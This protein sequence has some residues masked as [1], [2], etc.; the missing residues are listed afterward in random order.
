ML[1]FDW[2]RRRAAE[3]VALGIADGCREVGVFD[4]PADAGG[5]AQLRGLLAAPAIPPASDP[6][7][8]PTEPKRRRSA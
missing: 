8:E 5:I 4:G 1:L 6:P 3:A 2:I 7:A